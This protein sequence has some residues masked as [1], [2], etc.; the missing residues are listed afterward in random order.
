VSVDHHAAARALDR[1][2][3]VADARTALDTEEQAA[4]AAARSEGVSME[5]IAAALG[6]TRRNLY[7][8][9]NRYP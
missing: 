4:V 3:A 5:Q 2:R 6:T 1:V 7:K 8:R 9:L